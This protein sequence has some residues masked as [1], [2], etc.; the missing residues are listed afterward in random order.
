MKLLDVVAEYLH[1]TQPDLSVF[2][3][4]TELEAVDA[5]GSVLGKKGTR[6]TPGTTHNI[7][8]LYTSLVESID[9]CQYARMI[10]EGTA[11][12]DISLLRQSTAYTAPSCL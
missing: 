6:G 9:F 11:L 12:N 1:R 5:L 3:F 4:E 2:H 8:V 10:V 7:N